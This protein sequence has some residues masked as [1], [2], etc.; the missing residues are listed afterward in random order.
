MKITEAEW[1]ADG[2][3]YWQH[4]DGA[5]LCDECAPHE[6]GPVR[7]FLVYEVED[8]FTC[9]GCGALIIGPSVIGPAP[10][11]LA[12]LHNEPTLLTELELELVDWRVIGIRESDEAEIVATIVTDTDVLQFVTDTLADIYDLAPAPY[13]PAKGQA[14]YSRAYDAFV[15]VPDDARWQDV[16]VGRRVYRQKEGD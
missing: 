15:W 13:S 4:Q 8:W 1:L 11:A 6:A 3:R 7:P 12:V 9:D 10:F 2:Y 16:W 5:I 14:W